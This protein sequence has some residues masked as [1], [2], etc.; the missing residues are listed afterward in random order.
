MILATLNGWEFSFSDKW[1]ASHRSG[2]ET[3][4]FDNQE[5]FLKWFEYELN[6]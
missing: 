6:E 1:V 5:A 4:I 3:L 2:G